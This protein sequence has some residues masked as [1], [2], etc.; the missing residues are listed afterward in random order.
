MKKFND[1]GYKM[2]F[3]HPRMVEDLFKAFVK[4]DFVS[5]IDFSSLKRANNSYVTKD[6]KDRE[7]DILWQTKFKGKE[8]YIYILIEF[9]ST[10]DK[11]MSLRCLLIFCFFIRI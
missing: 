2:L 11:F 10:V 9:Q 4:E 3:S 7:A 5:E 8:A 6:F 1:R